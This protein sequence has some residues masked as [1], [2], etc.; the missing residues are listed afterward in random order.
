MELLT[1]G[2]IKIT[3]ELIAILAATYLVPWLRDLYKKWFGDKKKQPELPQQARAEMSETDKEKIGETR[4]II[5]NHFT[6]KPAEAIGNMSNMERVQA[7][8]DFV[9]DLVK[10][11]DLDIDVDVEIM[12]GSMWGAYNFETKKAVFNVA[13]LM[14]DKSHE[15]F[16]YIVKEFLD[17]I[18]HELR[19]AVQDKAI[20]TP[21]FW[22]ISDERRKAWADNMQHYINPKVDI[23]AYAKQPVENDAAS[24]A[25][26]ALEG[27]V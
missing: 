7:T 11:Y 14:V 15:K 13:Y 3:T 16:E 18:V 21:G 9:K 1:I 19:H 22:D 17:T 5:R 27:M 6:D 26:M 24:F 23:K 20:N 2:T 25:A 10:A 4:E 12:E 8:S